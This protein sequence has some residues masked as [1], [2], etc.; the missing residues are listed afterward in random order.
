MTQIDTSQRQRTGDQY[1]R[2]AINPH[3]SQGISV[4]A[5]PIANGVTMADPVRICEPQPRV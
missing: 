3:R 2:I 5:S 4:H 1:P